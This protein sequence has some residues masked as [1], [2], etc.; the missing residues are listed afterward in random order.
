ME[1]KTFKK[2]LSVKET[3]KISKLPLTKLCK[4]SKIEKVANKFSFHLKEVTMNIETSRITKYSDIYKVEDI[5]DIDVTVNASVVEKIG[6]KIPKLEDDE[7]VVLL[8]TIEKSR[9]LA[10]TSRYI[11]R[12]ISEDDLVEV[13][14]QILLYSRMDINKL[15]DVLEDL[16]YYEIVE[17]YRSLNPVDKIREYM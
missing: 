10:S 6:R 3:V 12:K 15:C 4:R 11:C 17:L 2:Y 9:L 14:V 7:I 5:E 16:K 13:S 1:E 8:A